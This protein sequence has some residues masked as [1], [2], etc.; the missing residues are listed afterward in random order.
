MTANLWKRHF[1]LDNIDYLGHVIEPERP[2]V[3]DKTGD[4]IKSIKYPTDKTYSMFLGLFD[5]LRT[6]CCVQQICVEPRQEST[7]LGHDAEEGNY[8]EI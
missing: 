4:F 6:V 1:F 2:L 5:V 7:L 8:D 3:A